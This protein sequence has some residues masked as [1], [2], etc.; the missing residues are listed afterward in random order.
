MKIITL[1]RKATFDYEI[2]DRIEAGVVLTGDE[3]K[4]IR[5]GGISLKD[6]YA[7]IHDGQIQ[8]LNCY[9]AP[10]SHAYEKKDLS[11]R[12][13]RLLL[14]RK[15]INKIIGEVS[16]KGLTLIPLKMYYGNRGYVKIEI[17]ICKH[18]KKTDKKQAIKER[19]I[20]RET[21]REMK[22]YV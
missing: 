17:G 14:H 19:D 21:D 13:R 20:K 3:I 15:Q 2:L 5:A 4:S 18:K 1:N 16:R 8:L 12:S 22:K 6:S 7:T 11:R 9:I 10:Y